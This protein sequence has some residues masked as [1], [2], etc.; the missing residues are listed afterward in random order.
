[1]FNFLFF[2]IIYLTN[3]MLTHNIM[4]ILFVLISYAV[5]SLI[6]YSVYMYNVS[7]KVFCKASI[8]Y[9]ALLVAV[10]FSFIVFE[11]LFLFN[12]CNSLSFNLVYN[13]NFIQKWF[14]DVN[15]VF[16]IDKLTCFY[17]F[18]VSIISVFANYHTYKYMHTDQKKEKFVFFLNSFAVSMLT[19]VISRNLFVIFLCWE[20]LGITSFFLISHN[21]TQTSSLKSALKAFSFNKVSDILLI[22]TFILFAVRTRSVNITESTIALFNLNHTWYNYDICIMLLLV[23]AASSIK[24]VQ[25]FTFM[26]LPDSMKAPAPA[27]ALIH[28]ATLVAAGF[29]CISLF[30]CVYL[31]YFGVTFMVSIGLITAI[32]GAISAAYQT[33][34]KRILAFSTI[35]NCGF[36]LVLLSVYDI[37]IFL[38]YFT[39]HGLFK[40]ACFMFSGDIIT[41]QSHKQDFRGYST[42]LSS[43]YI[44][45][46]CVIVCLIVLS[47]FPFTIT[48]FIKHQFLL[49]NLSL[50]F[51]S[52]LDTF[53]YVYSLASLLYASNYVA[54]L[55]FNIQSKRENSANDYAVDDY[56]LNTFYAAI[57][58]M[59]SVI[60]VGG[61]LVSLKYT[62]VG[63]TFYSMFSVNTY[64]TS[65]CTVFSVLT[66]YFLVLRGDA[67][68]WQDDSIDAISWFAWVIIFCVIVQSA[69]M[70][71][72]VLS[73]SVEFIYTAINYMLFCL[74][75]WNF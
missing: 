55:Y 65:V 28:S 38:I 45:L 58:M 54:R 71:S 52:I 68:M 8:C 20:L 27:S 34:L 49:S 13:I 63:N 10:S 64:I 75:L 3:S 25:F 23:F 47:G 44:N 14:F 5:V 16:C 40:S 43:K 72:S 60:F 50:Q 36:M 32:V 11:F 37:Y 2:K 67:R 24:S 53:F 39:V 18:T 51:W 48:F 33:D 73:M 4:F 41:A 9:W 17:V 57:S 30:R 1:M 42:L 7:F 26:W 6:L 29:Y 21:D 69:I 66:I 61:L 15:I 22:A 19:L 12:V 62:S 46:S 59:F 70:V 74:I 31:N 56:I 35:S